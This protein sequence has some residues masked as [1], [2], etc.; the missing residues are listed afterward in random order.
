MA[1][2]ANS[3]VTPQTPN[4]GLQQFV[5]G[6]D[7]T[8]AL[9]SLYVAGANGSKVLGAV[10]VSSDSASAHLVSLFV[11]NTGGTT[12]LAN[13]V[14]VTAGAGN[15]SATPPVA[16]MSAAV[17]PGLPVDNDGNPYLF[18]ANGDTLEAEYQTTLAA[19][20]TISLVCAATDY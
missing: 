7:T 9:K 3:I 20:S 13:T 1:V 6:T 2:T 17:W 16:L 12:F 8:L 11:K 5:Q 18:L 10:A 15:A 4:R 14:S 19:S